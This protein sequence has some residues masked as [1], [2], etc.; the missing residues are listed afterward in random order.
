MNIPQIY[1]R[2]RKNHLPAEICKSVLT[3]ICPR[4]PYKQVL[5]L[6]LTKFNHR[7][8]QNI[9]YR[10]YIDIGSCMQCL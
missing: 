1:K 6:S 9:D 8:Q 5:S 2:M 3:A 4:P 7:R 10:E